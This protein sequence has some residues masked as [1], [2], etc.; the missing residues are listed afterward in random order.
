MCFCP[1]TPGCYTFT[2][3]NLGK[4]ITFAPRVSNN[5]S[6]IYKQI[7]DKWSTNRFFA[8]NGTTQAKGIEFVVKRMHKQ[9]DHRKTRRQW[10][11][12]FALLLIFTSSLQV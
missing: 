6:H 3:D 1:L 5:L 11:L 4:E 8:K 12:E 10:K 9:K 7:K 2:A